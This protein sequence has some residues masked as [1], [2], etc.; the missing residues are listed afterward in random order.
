MGGKPLN[1]PVVGIAATATGG[2]WLG[3]R[4]GGVFSF[5]TPFYGSMGGHPLNKPV[6]GIAATPDDAGYYLVAADG[7]VFTFGDAA[8]HGSLGGKALNKPVVGIAVTPDNG[9]YYLASAD[10]GVFTFGDARF[11]GSMGDTPLNK[12][13][14]GIAVD[15]TTPA[16]GWSQ[17]TEECSPLGHP[18]SAPPAISTSTRQSLGWQLPRTISD[19][20]SSPP[21][22][23]CSA[24]GR[25]RS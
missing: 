2:Y 8:F 13:V 15:D 24:S 3:A 16:T 17:A 7:G 23:A 19:I 10:G 9:G 12:P 1:A 25:P 11:Q 21:T 14:V 20:A 6:V 18:S 4:D 5:G 22:A